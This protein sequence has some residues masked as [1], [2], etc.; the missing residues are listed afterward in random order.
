MRGSQGW[1]EL[2]RSEGQQTF[3]TAG[4]WSE[5][6][7]MWKNELGLG[8]E[9]GGGRRGA[10][11]LLWGQ[12]GATG[13]LR[14][15]QH[16]HAHVFQRC[17]RGECPH[18]WETSWEAVAT[19]PVKDEGDPGHRVGSGAET[20]GQAQAALKG[21]KVPGLESRLWTVWKIIR[22]QSNQRTP[23]QGHDRDRSCSLVWTHSRCRKLAGRGWY[24]EKRTWGGAHSGR[25]L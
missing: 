16:G 2:G 23:P 5:R 20:S 11:A 4:P 14:G 6:Q 21:A 9:V 10:Q 13:G 15:P 19:V 25:S 8:R 18:L 12:W 3:C 7:K 17:M 1:R 24:T 22:K